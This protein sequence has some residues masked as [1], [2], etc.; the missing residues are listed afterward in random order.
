MCMYFV[1]VA[2]PSGLYKYLLMSVT[3]K[4]ISQCV[5]QYS[6]LK[7]LNQVKMKKKLMAVE[8]ITEII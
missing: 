8:C 2:Y 1:N 3:T 7:D 5:Q 6:F 4:K